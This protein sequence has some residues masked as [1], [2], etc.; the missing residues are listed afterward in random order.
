MNYTDVDRLMLNRWTEVVALREAFDTLLERM[1]DTIEGALKKTERWTDEK[2]LKTEIDLKEPNLDVWK[3]EWAKRRDEPAVCFRIGEFAPLEFGRVEHDHPW[4]WLITADVAGF[5]LNEEG[6][7][8]FARQLRA[9]L[10][11]A[12][13]RWDNPD[14][15][16][17]DEPLG[18]YCIEVTDADRVRWMSQPDELTE[19]LTRG[20][21]ELMTLAPAIDTVLARFKKT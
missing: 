9:E 10:G 20:I 2:G 18:R 4:L 17:A 11:Q 12:V 7:V 13:T 14:A 6:R 5:K 8:Q 19:F 21:D 16:E 1:E 15:V 3:P